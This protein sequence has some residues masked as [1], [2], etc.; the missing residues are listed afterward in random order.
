MSVIKKHTIY[1]ASFVK[2]D[3]DEDDNSTL[4]YDE[5]IPLETSLNSLSGSYDI[6]IY[7]DKIKTMCKTMLDYD[8]WINKIKEK[9][10]V[11]LYGATPDDEKVNGE[12]ANYYVDAV[13]PQN[14]K[15]L[16]YFK[17]KI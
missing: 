5:P 2:E 15:I 4:I 8:Q 1:L 11:Y 13:L 12:N 3:M 10:A 17:K 16:V 7:G 9:D 14:K 6:S